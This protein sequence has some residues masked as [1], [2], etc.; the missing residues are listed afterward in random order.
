MVSFQRRPIY[1]GQKDSVAGLCHYLTETTKEG[2]LW[3]CAHNLQ[4]SP[5]PSALGVGQMTL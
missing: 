1:A 5:N 2:G 3:R 4:F